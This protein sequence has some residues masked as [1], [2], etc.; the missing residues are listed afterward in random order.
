MANNSTGHYSYLEP[1]THCDIYRI[2]L[3]V[4]A[5]AVVVFAVWAYSVIFS[6]PVEENLTVPT[7]LTQSPSALI[8]AQK[9][10]IMERVETVGTQPLTPAEKS[11]IVNFV[12]RGGATYTTAE[13][14]ALTKVLRGQ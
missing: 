10:S 2:I 6:L 12:S 3:L 8:A 13:K 4:L 11:S 14:D 9:N 1:E 5:L 7:S